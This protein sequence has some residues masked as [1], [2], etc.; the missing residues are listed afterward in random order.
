MCGNAKHLGGATHYK[1]IWVSRGIAIRAQEE[2]SAAAAA[3]LD[4]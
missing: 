3:M 4:S 2:L 1:F